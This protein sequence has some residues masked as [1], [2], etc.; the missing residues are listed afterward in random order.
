MYKSVVHN[1]PVPVSQPKPKATQAEEPPPPQQQKQQ[2]QNLDKMEKASTKSKILEIST[3]PTIHT[4][5]THLSSATQVVEVLQRD[6]T[7]T[8]ANRAK[9][10]VH[11]VKSQIQRGKDLKRDRAE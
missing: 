1:Q 10:E 2:E 7:A 6:L 8:E 11:A 4:L 3:T 9:R 5:V